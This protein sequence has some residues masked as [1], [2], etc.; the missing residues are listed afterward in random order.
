MQATR[1][2]W[3]G[4]GALGV[5]A[6]LAH[7][8]LLGGLEWG[9]PQRSQA[10]RVAAMQVRAIEAPLASPSQAE[11]V[12]VVVSVDA[13]KPVSV[14]VPVVKAARVRVA[15]ATPVATVVVVPSPSSEPARAAEGASIVV[16]AAP[17]PAPT[18]VAPAWNEPIPHYRTQLPPPITLHYVMQRGA[19]RGSGELAWR[20]GA[21]RYELKLDGSVAGLSVLT[22]ISSGGI[23]GAGVAPLRFT[24]QR[25]R[26]GTKAANFRRE[27]G[28]IS[29]SGS[30]AEFPLDEG[31]QDRLS[32]MVQLGAIVAAEPKLRSI[33]AKVVMHVV[34]A[35]ADASVWIFDCVAIESVA[36][37]AGTVSALKF[38]REPREPYD[39]LVQVWLDPE[40]HYLPV[41]ATQKSGPS[42]EGFELRLQSVDT[43]P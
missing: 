2:R 39:T 8:L 27:V 23:D 36:T 41:R 43:H 37:G 26:R 18:T 9:W 35:N 13:V 22:Q 5:V 31:A 11:T 38:V 21:D 32:W 28:K 30:T 15:P 10:G 33:G 6:L 17:P 16:A 14:S 1:R 20:P 3:V 42:D 7:A 12:P 40:R 34:G 29:F 19:L 25:L 4:L 24:D